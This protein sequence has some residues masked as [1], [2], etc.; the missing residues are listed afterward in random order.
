MTVDLKL[1]NG[2]VTPGPPRELFSFPNTINNQY[3]VS[4]DGRQIL[5]QTYE[6]GP[7]TTVIVNWTALLK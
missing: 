3:S 5:V 2:T 4:A 1:T 7:L 6:G